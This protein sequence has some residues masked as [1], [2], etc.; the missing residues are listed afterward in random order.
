MMRDFFC[1]G[2]AAESKLEPRDGR[3]Y[4]K[5][6]FCCVWFGRVRYLQKECVYVCVCEGVKERKRVV[7]TA[8]PI[9]I[10][11]FPSQEN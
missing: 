10:P 11:S 1:G 8:I 4:I 9:H 2:G 3:P 6:A 7:L 5:S